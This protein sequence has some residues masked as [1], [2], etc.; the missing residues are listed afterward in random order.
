MNEKEKLSAHLVH[1][2]IRNAEDFP[3][4]DR[5]EVYINEALWEMVKIYSETCKDYYE[6]LYPSFDGC[7]EEEF[8]AWDVAPKWEDPRTFIMECPFYG[9]IR[10]RFYKE[11]ELKI[12]IQKREED[13]FRQ[14][15]CCRESAKRL[16]NTIES[17]RLQERFYS[18]KVK[19]LS[20]AKAEMNRLFNPSN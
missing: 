8:E 7:N 10:F 17:K 4:E 16:E 3:Y 13:L 6:D 14:Y 9:S 2:E 1:D 12:A 19:S 11:K 20:D 18:W 5:I 15:D